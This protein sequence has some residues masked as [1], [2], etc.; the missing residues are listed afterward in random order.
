MRGGSGYYVLPR[1][2]SR[3]AR[4]CNF[5]RLGGAEQARPCRRGKRVGP[6]PSPSTTRSS[7]DPAEGSALT[8]WGRPGGAGRGRADARPFPVR[9]FSGPQAAETAPTPPTGTTSG[10]REQR[11]HERGGSR[12]GRSRG[13][14][15]PAWD[16][17]SGRACPGHR[18][19][20]AARPGPPATR[21]SHRR[22][23]RHWHT[24]PPR[25]RAQ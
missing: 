8:A 7:Q 12:R 1:T 2:P 10:N 20:P 11:R 6:S 24:R 15:R 4:R 25:A 23:P 5:A 13:R 21:P 14:A 22:R 19:P 3:G 17:P 18:L 9:P 16:S